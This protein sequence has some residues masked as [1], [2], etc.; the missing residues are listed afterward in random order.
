MARKSGT[1][2]S[3]RLNGKAISCKKACECCKISSLKGIGNLGQNVLQLL[4]AILDPAFTGP[5]PDQGAEPDLALVSAFV[6]APLPGTIPADIPPSIVRAVP[7]NLIGKPGT[8]G[9]GAVALIAFEIIRSLATDEAVQTAVATLSEAI[10]PLVAAA[11]RVADRSCERCV[12]ERAWG[13]SKPQRKVT[14]PHRT[15]NP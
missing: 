6:E 8:A 4:S 15:R 13:Q 12:E 1:A 3:A 11:R 2:C 14:G 9:A 10:P 7:R 5:D